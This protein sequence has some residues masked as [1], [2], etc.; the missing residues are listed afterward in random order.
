[1][2]ALIMNGAHAGDAEIDAAAAFLRREL[3]AVGIAAESLCLRDHR[4]AY[5]RGC[6][7]CWVHTPGVCRTRDAGRDIARDWIRSDLV[8]LLTPVTF[9]GYSS[10]LK[11]A[12][13]RVICLVSPFFVRIGGEVHHRPRYARYPGLF[14]IGW[15][16]AGDEEEARTFHTLVARNALNMHAPVHGSRVLCRGGDPATGMRELAGSLPIGNWR[17]A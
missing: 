9:G 12:L 6:F 2:R 13:D 15:Q 4:L 1:M 16:D 10:E 11:K 14:A 8:V 7:N 5:C 17:A 3:E